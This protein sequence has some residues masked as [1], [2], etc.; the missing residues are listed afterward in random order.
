MNDNKDINKMISIFKE[1]NEYITETP[2]DADRY[3][4]L[5][6]PSIECPF[7]TDEEIEDLKDYYSESGVESYHNYFNEMEDTWP[8]HNNGKSYGNR[9]IELQNQMKVTDDQDEVD[10]IKQNLVD[11]GW[12]P[13][14]EYNAETQIM[15]RNRYTSIINERLNND[16]IIDISSL[17]ESANYNIIFESK[18]KDVKSISLIFVEGSRGISNIIKKVTNCDFSHAAIALDEDFNT[19]YSFNLDNHTKFNG[20]F[21]LES[22]KH[23]PQENRLA[24]YTFFI[25]N[26]DYDKIKERVNYLKDHIKDTAYGSMTLLL[27]PFKNIKFDTSEIMICSQFVDACMKMVDIDITG[28]HSSKVSPASLYNSASNH[29]KIYKIYDGKVKN[30]NTK[31]V[32]KIFNKIS[33]KATLIKESNINTPSILI[34]EARS[35]PIEVNN[36]GD[37]L[38]TNPYPDFDAEYMASHKLLIQYDKAKNIEAMKYELARLYYMNYILEKKLYHNKFLINKEKNMKTRARILND[39]NKYIKVILAAEPDFNFGEYYQQ[40]QFYPHTIEVKKSTLDAAKSIFRYI[41]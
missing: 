12:N 41:L 14:I 9:V 40:S 25:N 13:E 8:F 2:S 34:M 27:F 15:A 22:I 11:I 10:K 31:K 36:N 26:K 38:I 5:N 19:L 4:I 3:K 39:Y 7:F 30:F 32:L 33:K 35:L 37:V 16:D 20:G 21:S 28:F 1:S 6:W 29:S 23:Y 17:L 24:I 18:K